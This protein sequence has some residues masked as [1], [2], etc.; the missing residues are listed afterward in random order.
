MKHRKP[1]LIFSAYVFAFVFTVA[2]IVG[3]GIPSMPIKDRFLAEVETLAKLDGDD[4]TLAGGGYSRRLFARNA[5][6]KF[7]VKGDPDRLIVVELTRPLHVFDWRLS[8]YS[9]D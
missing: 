6:M 8:G 3:L 2:A 9:D 4:L 1:I 5:H 7:R